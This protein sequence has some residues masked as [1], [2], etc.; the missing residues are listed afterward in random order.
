MVQTAMSRRGLVCLQLAG[1]CSRNS[2]VS[3]FL[4][5]SL[6][7]SAALYVQVF[8]EFQ[9]RDGEALNLTLWGLR[10]HN[11]LHL[12]PPEEEDEDKGSETKAFYCC[13]PG[14]MSSGLVTQGLCLLW[15]FNQTA[16]RAAAH[17]Q[18]LLPKKGRS[19]IWRKTDKNT[20]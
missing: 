6:C 7:L 1:P 11:S 3:A 17:S 13:Y 19:E 14:S 9:F 15:L 2:P 16:L 20:C 5:C 12:Q 4:Y 10:N 8:V 18:P